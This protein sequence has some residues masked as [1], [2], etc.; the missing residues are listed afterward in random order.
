MT[1]DTPAS[2]DRCIRTSDDAN[3]EQ[4]LTGEQLCEYCQEDAR[5]KDTTRELGQSSLGAVET[6]SDDTG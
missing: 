2:C 5:G 4:T 3:I 1:S 6:D